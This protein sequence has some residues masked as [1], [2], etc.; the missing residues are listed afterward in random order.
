MA[1]HDP[2]KLRI[3]N[4]NSPL[5]AELQTAAQTPKIPHR[6]GASAAY[7]DVLA[8]RNLFSTCGPGQNLF[9]YRFT[10]DA[11]N[12]PYD[13]VFEGVEFLSRFVVGVRA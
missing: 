7:L 4:P 9:S 8:G 3:K 5:D 1:I 12:Q 13:L 6:R 2:D 10:H 11:P